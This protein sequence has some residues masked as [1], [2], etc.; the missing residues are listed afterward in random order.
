MQKREISERDARRSSTIPSPA[1]LGVGASV[2][3]GWSDPKGST[4]W[5]WLGAFL[6]L[7]I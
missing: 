1:A 5:E 6:A 4:E 2:E 3:D 7:F